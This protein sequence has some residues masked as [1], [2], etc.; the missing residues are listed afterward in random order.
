M[1]NFVPIKRNVREA[2]L[3]CSYLKKS[4]AESQRMLSETYGDYTPSISTREYD[5]IKK[6]DFNTEDKERS[7]RKSLKMRKWKLYSIETRVN[8]KID[9]LQNH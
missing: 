9:H 7:G 5:A 6:D 8:H 4:A 2:L 1:S 3:F